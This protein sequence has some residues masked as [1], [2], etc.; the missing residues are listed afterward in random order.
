MPYTDATRHLPPH[1]DVIRVV[2]S[3]DPAEL[4][5]S[6]EPLRARLPALLH[7]GSAPS[8]GPR[9]SAASETSGTVTPAKASV[10]RERQQAA[11]AS[12]G[13]ERRLAAEQL[14]GLAREGERVLVTG[15]LYLLADLAR[16]E[17]AGGR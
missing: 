7:E 8:D 9:A 12:E 14:E 3:G 10:P 1:L 6:L 2:W 13:S 17:D 15:S 5:Q 16:K 11:G 4:A